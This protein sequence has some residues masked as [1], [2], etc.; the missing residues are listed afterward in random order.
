MYSFLLSGF[1]LCVLLSQASA[2]IR[3]SE[4]LAR[5]ETGLR[6]EDGQVADWIEIENVGEDA[7]SLSGWTLTDNP[8]RLRKW[9][10]PSA[11]LSAGERRVLF[12]TSKDRQAP[13]GEWH[14]SFRLSAPG[15]TLALVMPDGETIAHQIDAAPQFDD[16]SYGV[17]GVTGNV[18][19]LENV[20][21]G[22]L[23]GGIVY[24]GPVIAEVTHAS[25]PLM[26]GEDV[27]I[28][29]TVNARGAA[30]SSVTLISA[31]GLG[32]SSEEAMLDD[33]EGS[34]AVA[35]DGIY[36]AVIDGRTLFGDRIKAGDMVRWAVL[37]TDENGA[38]SRLPAYL[39]QEGVE[40]SPEYFGTVATTSDL[41]TDL[42]VLEWFT[43]DTRNSRTRTG[44]RASVAFM[45]RFYDNIYV[46]ARGGATNGQSQKFN[47]SNAF[48]CYVNEALPAVGELNLNAQGGDATHLRQ[49]LAFE[50]YTWIGNAACAS[51]L[52]VM[53]LNGDDDRTGVLIE[54]VDEDFLERHGFDPL[55]DL[56]KMVQ[57]SNLNPVFADTTTG[58]EK[59]TG[60][61]S[62]LSSIASLV[63]GLDKEGDELK[64]YLF[65]S[66]NLPQVLNY[67]AVRCVTQDADDVRK[68]FYV[69]QDSLGD[70][71]W[72]IFPWD[73][74]WTFGVTGDG[75]QFLKHP[76][77]GDEARRKDNANQWNKLYD[78]IFNQAATR[79][80]YLRRL[81]TVMDTIL[82]PE[83][84]PVAELRY[85]ARVDELFAQAQSDVSNS[86][87][88][89]VKRF[90]PE[91]RRDLYET[92]D[93]LIPDAQ[94][95]M[96]RLAFGDIEF[97]PASGIQDEEYVQL[98]NLNRSPVDLS[99]WTLE[100]GVDYTFAEGTVIGAG[101]VFTPGLNRLYVSPSVNV[102]R[103]R[104]V[105]PTGGEGLFVQGPY[106]GHLSNRGET[107]T[108]K[109]REGTVIAEVSYEGNPSEVER[110]LVLSEIMYHP[111][112]PNGAAE[113]IELYNVSDTVTLDLTGLQF[114]D[115]IEFAFADGAMLEPNA[116][117][118]LVRE[119]AAF[120]EVYGEEIAIAGVFENQTRLA[121]AGERL[122]LDDALNSTIFEVRY[123][124]KAPWPEGAD[125][126]GSS[127]NI[128]NLMAG[129]DVE[130]SES[131]LAGAGSPGQ[132]ANLEGGGDFVDADGDG[133]LA[134]LEEAF[135]TS[136]Q[137]ASQ[138]M[139]AVS[140]TEEDDLLVVRA[141]SSGSE[142]ITV[143][144]QT[145][146][147]L[148]SWVDAG[149]DRFVLTEET[150]GDQKFFVWTG[151]RPTSE[152]SFQA[153]RISAKRL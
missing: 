111:A 56:Y 20:T 3:I 78:A 95:A 19:Y 89:T 80:M 84:T 71:E 113:F 93:A 130:T 135:G 5:N 50:S 149:D 85:E 134:L 129:V 31:V 49:P 86:G 112:D 141:P 75:G 1:S 18:G 38:T 79:E 131:W 125:G 37:A 83:G 114:T 17:D 36:T 139:S 41:D 123:N 55:G 132:A 106:D 47:F 33:G 87:A 88:T 48:P 45:G 82:Q 21:P 138:G 32:A 142:T 77:F 26:P 64:A 147:A 40:Q 101:N 7:V 46:R 137:D 126:L 73:K 140:V 98:I 58:I 99:G 67:L 128:A 43:N 16:I 120:R 72:S 29:A 124:D 100:G 6:D 30:T 119:E 104:A 102:F 15:E 59:K 153:I 133:L 63:D 145:S 14:T 118:V 13:E 81:R 35:D 62:D 152:A 96:P 108:L 116:Y 2:Q 28:T 60:D 115:G 97:Q 151:T 121:N 92:Y 22:A 122:K 52:T 143:V 34:D 8:N 109:D 127:I 146:E 4:F 76:F 61:L 110:F 65:D 51:F 10:F 144:L 11:D 105:S 39:D 57:R 150:I 91:R 25:E 24:A 54:Q 148:T 23:N 27:V 94:E 53:R 69:Y 42:P 117:L 103:Q 44:A 107:L 68:N 136:D 90:F 9:D 74:D 70:G 66:I 12:A